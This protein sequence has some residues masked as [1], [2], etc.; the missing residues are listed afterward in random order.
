MVQDQAL[1]GI[2]V[3]DISGS[4]STGFCAKVFA[5]Y[6]A[7]VINLEPE[8][9][10]RT[11]NLAPLIGGT[12]PNASAMHAWLST[13]KKSVRADAIGPAQC[14][15]IIGEADLLLDDGQEHGFDCG[16]VRSSISWYGRGGPYE[17]FVGT[18]AQCF[19]LNGMIRNIGPIEGPPIMTAGYQAE[20]TA[21]ITAYTASLAQVLAGELGNRRNPVHIETSIFESCICFTDVGAVGFHNS[22]LQASRMGINRFPPTYPLGVF[23]CRDGWIGVTVLTPS[24]WHSFCKLLGMDELAEVPLFQSSVGRLQARDVIEPLMCER[25]ETFSAEDLFYKGQQAA[26]PLA[27]VPTMEELFEVDQFQIRNAMTEATLPDG[28]TLRVPSVAF[29]LYST[30]P[31]FGGPVA[32]LGQHSGDYA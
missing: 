5:D 22:G 26:I 3:V 19:A 17:N 13:N 31:S 11:R 16:G 25:F 4:V 28:E 9:G 23:P 27:R 18:D 2:R 1:A 15:T 6:G 7:D 10:F 14:A 30:P 32:A 8:G 29:R 24:Q 20:V 12:A 21:G